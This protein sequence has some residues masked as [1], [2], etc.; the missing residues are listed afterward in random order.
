MEMILFCGIQAT[1]KTTFFLKHFFRTHI[2][3]SLDQLHTRNKEDKFLQLCLELQQPFIV[4]NTN[5]TKAERQKYIALARERRFRVKGYYFQSKL[6]DAIER[7]K[8]RTGKEHIPEVGIK[9]TY[10]RLEL[11]TP[12]EGFDTL[13]YVSLQDNEFI[14]KP[15]DHEI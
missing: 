4:D 15:W 14:I 12:E 8:R 9:G 6:P 5:P 3:I 2:R 13:F 11:P 7:N 10:G 1:G